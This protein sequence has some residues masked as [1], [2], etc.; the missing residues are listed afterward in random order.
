MAKSSKTLLED[1]PV[2]VIISDVNDSPL[3]SENMTG[4]DFIL[5]KSPAWSLMSF[6]EWVRWVIY[7]EPLYDDRQIVIW[8]NPYVGSLE[9]VTEP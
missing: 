5:E 3:V 8:M 1:V 9:V 6:Q 2:D 4:Q 7:Q